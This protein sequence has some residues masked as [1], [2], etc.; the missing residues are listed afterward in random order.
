MVAKKQK[1]KPHQHFCTRC[2]AKWDCH[3]EDKK[4]CLR[5]DGFECLDCCRR[6]LAEKKK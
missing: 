1:P 3:V 4:D 5:D 6:E 2:K